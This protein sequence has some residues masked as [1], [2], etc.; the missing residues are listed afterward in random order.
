M[1]I[2]HGLPQSRTFG[3][4]LSCDAFTASTTLDTFQRQSA[5]YTS[6]RLRIEIAR[7]R[8]RTNA[9]WAPLRSLPRHESDAAERAGG[10]GGGRGGGAGI[11]NTAAAP[12]Q[13]TAAAAVA[14]ATTATVEGIIAAASTVR[15]KGSRVLGPFADHQITRR[16]SSN[17]AV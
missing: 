5:C 17:I 4:T 6:R 2:S 1:R 3:E 7:R 9:L 14:N 12:S 15:L 11:V 10:G 16:R 8:T 13:L